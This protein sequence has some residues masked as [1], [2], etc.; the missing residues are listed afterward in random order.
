MTNCEPNAW[1]NKYC[2]LQ[3]AVNDRPAQDVREV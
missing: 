1:L 2:L 3:H